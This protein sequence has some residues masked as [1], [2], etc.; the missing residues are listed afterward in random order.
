MVSLSPTSV[1]I[2]TIAMGNILAITPHDILQL[3]LIAGIS[4]LVFDTE[5]ERF[6]GD[7]F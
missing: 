5:M 2:Q 6:D 7:V 4:L 3:S 1:N